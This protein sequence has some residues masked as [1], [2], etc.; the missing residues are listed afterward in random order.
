MALTDSA[1]EAAGLSFRDKAMLVLGS[2]STLGDAYCSIAWGRCVAED[3][4]R[5]R[6][7]RCRRDADRP[8]SSLVSA[9]S[10]L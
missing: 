6:A 3:V 7:A 2:A 5:L 10:D 9:R 1:A 4:D 8:S